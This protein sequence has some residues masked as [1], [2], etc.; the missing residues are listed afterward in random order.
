M[1]S[2]STAS[3]PT[4]AA[5]VVMDRFVSASSSQDA[6]ESLEQMVQGFQSSSTT[7]TT[8]NN[9][10]LAATTITWQPL[11]ILNH[12]ELP[13]H[14]VWLL[15]HGTLKNNE[16]P[17]D[18][19]IGL[20]CQ[21]Y[22]QLAKQKEALMVPTPGL[23]L[24]SL[25]DVLDHRQEQQQLHPVYVRVLALKVLEELSK[26]HKSTAMQQWLQA[27]N[28]L[29]RLAD[30]ISI[31]V[32]AQ[33][34]EEP[35]RDQA[36][37]VA[38]LLAKEAPLAK[39][40]LF[41]E[42]D[43]KLLDICWK[44]G[45][46]TDGK[47]IVVDALQL[48]VEL[49]KHADAS[50]QDLVWQRPTLPPRLMQ[51]IDLR[52]GLEFRHPEKAKGNRDGA[53]ARSKNTTDDNDEE[54]DLDS[55]L[56][57][58][59]TKKSKEPMEE[60]NEQQQDRGENLPKLTTSE[61]EV[62]SLALQI[63]GLLL[64]G[65]SLRHAIWKQHYP[66]FELIWDMSRLQTTSPPICALPS[67][68][69]QQKA[70]SL[71][72]EKINDSHLMDSANR[73][74]SLLAMVCTGG[75]IAETFDE[76]LATSQAAL[77][78]LRH[79]LS[80]DAIHDILMRTIAPPPT[81]D[82]DG[83]RAGP[84]VVQKLWATVLSLLKGEKSEN[85][86]ILLS[87]AFGGLGLMLCDEQSREI[88]SKL[89]PISMDELLESVFSEVEELIQCSMLRFLCEWTFQCPLV[90]H[91]LLRSPSSTHL[92]GMAV[93][94]S[95]HQSLVHLLLG[96]TM[97]SLTKEEDCGGWT[98][99]GMLQI[100]TKVG[101]SKFTSSLESLKTSQQD[102]N[103]PW[104]VSDME[105]KSWKKFCS[106]SVLIVRKR[107]VEELSGGSG[108][109]DSDNDEDP[110]QQTS[111]SY[112]KLSTKPLRKLI[113]QQAK[114]M[115][116][117]RQQLEQ[118]Q[119][120]VV[121][122][123]G[124]VETWRR[125]I[126]S[127]PTDLDNMLNEF[128]N[129][130][131]AL[132]ETVR[133]LEARVVEKTAEK[134]AAVKDL[135]SK[136]SQAQQETERIRL[137]EQEARDNLERTEQ[138]MQALSQAYSNLEV[139]YQRCQTVGEA[140]QHHSTSPQQGGHGSLEIV[141]LRSENDRLR[142]DAKAADEWMKLAVEKMNE[143]GTSNGELQKQVAILQG[144]LD[145]F[146]SSSHQ[147]LLHQ[148]AV[149]S[150]HQQIESENKRLQESLDAA[151]C[152]IQAH[153][154]RIAELEQRLVLS[155]GELSDLRGLRKLLESEKERA[156]QLEDRV[157][158][159]GA[160][161]ADLRGL[162]KVLE[163]EKQRSAQL[164]AM[165]SDSKQGES[166]IQQLDDALTCERKKVVELQQRLSELEDMD[167]LDEEV[168]VS[169]L[170]TE[171]AAMI[172]SK[173]AEI[174]LLK[175]ALVRAK[176][177]DIHLD[178]KTLI[179]RL[180]NAKKELEETKAKSQQD[181]YRLESVIRELKDRLGSGL[182]A[183]T[184]EDIQ[185]R[186]E[187]IEELRKANDSAQSWMAKALEH[188]QMSAAQITKLTEEKSALV[189]QLSEK[190]RQPSC[191]HD[192]NL[193]LVHE[194]LTERNKELGAMK[195]QYDAL[196]A[197]F[198]RLKKEMETNQ[199]L[200]DELGIAMEDVA[201][202]Q[203]KL[204]NSE[205]EKK[206]LEEKL[207]RNDSISEIQILE[208]ANAD[209]QRR[210][211]DL[212]DWID[213]AQEKI[214]D[215]LASKDALQKELEEAILEKE[216]LKSA[217][218][219]TERDHESALEALNET[220]E[221]LERHKKSADATIE[222]QKLEIE[223]LSEEVKKLHKSNNDLAEILERTKEH[224][225][226]TK[227]QEQKS[228]DLLLTELRAKEEE[229]KA[230]NEELSEGKA[231][232]QT[233]KDRVLKLESEL[234]EM[235]Q[236]LNHSQ[237]EVVKLQESC[238]VTD[239]QREDMEAKLTKALKDKANLELKV[240]SL[241]TP[242]L[243]PD[244]DDV[245]HLDGALST[246]Q[247]S[248]A[249]H[250]DE[251]HQLEVARSE[252]EATVKSLQLQLQE[253]EE[254]ANDAID[255]W[256][257]A[258]VSAGERCTALEEELQSLKQIQQ[259]V[260]TD[261]S[262]EEVVQG[263]LQSS[264]EKQR[265]LEEALKTIEENEA[266]LL[267]LKD[268]ITALQQSLKGKET[269][270]TKVIEK[271]TEKLR[272]AEEKVESIQE[273]LDSVVFEKDERLKMEQVQT[274]ELIQQVKALE[275]QLGK[276]RS[277]SDESMKLMELKVQSYEFEN[278]DL[279]LAANE[280][281]TLKEQMISLESDWQEKLSKSESEKGALKRRIEEIRLQHNNELQELRETICQDEEIVRQW[282][283]RT[284]AL[285]ET[286]TNLENKVDSLEAEL[287]QQENEAVNVISLWEE[288]FS[289]LESK[290]VSMEA[291][292]LHC[293][294]T[295]ASRDWTIEQLK[296]KNE[297][298]SLQLDSLKGAIQIKSAMEDDLV[299]ASL[300]IS[301][302][303]EVLELERQ[304]RLDERERYEAELANERGRHSEARDEIESL[305]SLLEETKVE[306]EVVVNQW[307]ARYEEINRS[308]LDAQNL[309]KEQEDDANEAISRW[310]LKALELER[311]L[312]LAEEQL[313][314]LKNVLGVDSE[315]IDLCSMVE[316]KL[317]LELASQKRLA[318]AETK[319]SLAEKKTFELSSKY[320]SLL[321]TEA[322]L[323]LKLRNLEDSSEAKIKAIS[324]QLESKSRGK[325][326]EERDRLKIIITQLEEELREANEMVQ[327]CIT[328][329]S[330][331]KATEAAA[332]ALREQIQELQAQ[333]DEMKRKYAAEK[334]AKEVAMLEVERLREDLAFLVSL[335]EDNGS[336][337]N[338]EKLTAQA[339][340]KVRRR[341]RSE[342]D[343]IKRSLFRAMEDL[344]A[345][346]SAE[347]TSNEKLSKARLQLSMYE[348]EIIAA[349]SEISFLTHA[350]EELRD[351][352]ES[353]RASLEYRMGSLEHEN[354][355]VRKY[356]AA[357]LESVRN[358]LSQITMDRD[359]VLQQL[360]EIE[361]TNASLVYA[362]S[363]ED[364]IS[365]DPDDL[366]SEC[367]RLRIENA[368]LLTMAADDKVRAERRL[369]EM[370]GAQAASTEADVILQ[371]E[372]RVSAETALESLKVELAALQK[373]RNSLSERSDSTRQEAFASQI[374]ELQSARVALHNLKKENNDLREKLKEA[375]HEA[376]SK[377]E[378]LTDEC[379]TAQAKLHK[380]NQ[381][382]RFE[383]LVEAEKLKMSRQPQSPERR[384][385]SQ[386]G[387]GW[388]I[389]AEDPLSI[390]ETVGPSLS[391]A[392]AFDLIQRQKEEIL[393]ERKMFRDTMQEYEAAL[394]LLAQLDSEKTALV[395][396]LG[397]AAS[398]E[399]I[400]KAHR[401]TSLEI[402][403]SY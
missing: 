244:T 300:E 243:F 2:T 78:V 222:K 327:A 49:L 36:L 390:G 211:A 142:N 11:W 394:A 197:Q 305:N 9:D 131:T 103:M 206:A 114:E 52:G 376:R 282:E 273:D 204:M 369:R 178:D 140:N 165:L 181:I 117:L 99:A 231:I 237:E 311:E 47:P 395:E 126:E 13:R 210:T 307:S 34:L 39:V 93:T 86:T 313:T 123:E 260:A 400:Q 315:D 221:V 115:D 54:D 252:L 172:S 303:T 228:T 367:A 250:E 364:N 392:E 372:L 383:A 257:D 68:T 77:A 335:S 399:A 125:R 253:Q 1:A 387:N 248:N 96:L 127:T 46:M 22:Q 397:V 240:K 73:L 398:E 215:I 285:S 256:Q 122:Q 121:F 182:G 289:D 66:L 60:Q 347:R 275:E 389:A 214:S 3:S 163:S 191:E 138:E 168:R 109:E 328:D 41:A 353:K 344:D 356:H 139:E 12:D 116:D 59:A 161:M 146:R 226:N 98:R 190:H 192:A 338:L 322:A 235:Q 158:A 365:V 336:A 162:R 185:S 195:T 110:S 371:S 186:D 112:S 95:N 173:D 176:E 132:E 19:G 333:M 62:V 175:Q 352:E 366:E 53:K 42:V 97:E 137:Q 188:H 160:E 29:H 274:S 308:L 229:L 262:K 219:D 61:E 343:E 402:I 32:D 70:L 106:Q 193:K 331:E 270:A 118:A 370:L 403:D 56:A 136:L 323:K 337:H 102:F 51:L 155:E 147:N 329:D 88:M 100:I 79:T 321:E 166:H 57:S 277:E 203:Q 297:S 135:E 245:P 40:F 302:L 232:I 58:G 94:P 261:I 269:E 18:E 230:A 82:V 312:D 63:F 290:F 346:R 23:L 104:M 170:R 251:L 254:A 180:D 20:V 351:A 150:D 101:I 223:G 281:I 8:S 284:T 334:S 74:D 111:G 280:S 296:S 310:E 239:Q 183:Y 31:D 33:P 368:H 332:H 382:G 317:G 44:N 92:A 213:I 324:R 184:T 258:C 90:A 141:T 348:Q 154:T 266:S 381:D 149:Q 306:S 279:K 189:K 124:Q 50:L 396:A 299:E 319:L 167:G 177:D 6:V 268:Q 283:I 209:L 349:K 375:S 120:K 363:K 208:R 236:K 207:S 361:K 341:E 379:R 330:G 198:E 35:V 30:L 76:K 85:R 105:F 37:Q 224:I 378:A 242:S 134:E 276:Q 205:S 164:E 15:Q 294:E 342:I 67:S 301:R 293:N 291:E 384:N 350:M 91:N 10:T 386:N 357:E 89:A 72:A 24:E 71:V 200:F 354:D 304:C 119:A 388:I 27:P 373:E 143:L 393:Q 316:S 148:A 263:A 358:E 217:L 247:K 194:Q 28:G 380:M 152:H 238:D 107:V 309:L 55:L 278:N 287:A 69:L 355:M 249:E 187:Q 225:D 26:R 295:I 87:G 108:V 377:I 21:L 234:N 4:D 246:A 374:D 220:I 25:L 255:Q 81:E 75:T 259:V 128:Q 43:S 216:N 241:E 360:K 144:E 38:K 391:S 196:Q 199:G 401:D 169:A 113:S 385:L 133:T 286:V 151:N 320:E 48:V 233:W 339:I 14:L 202:M 83:P 359:R 298:S 157:A 171:F 130:T 7:T 318:E 314:K 267:A 201:I 340:E 326:E 218:D 159:A 265:E 153:M 65:E 179:E 80:G 292:L 129:K 45:G 362:G 16:V 325:L 174:A 145:Q 64:D 288:N 17:C 272:A 264:L 227:D 5:V 345:A 156:A 212:Q 84:T 271:L